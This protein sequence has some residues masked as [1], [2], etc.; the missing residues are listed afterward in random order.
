MQSI[1][2]WIDILEKQ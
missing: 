2:V 1:L